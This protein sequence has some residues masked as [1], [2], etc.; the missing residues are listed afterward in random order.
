MVD[1]RSSL[2]LRRQDKRNAP[3]RDD[4]MSIVQPGQNRFSTNGRNR[5]NHH[6]PDFMTDPNDTNLPGPR[7]AV[8]NDSSS[9]TMST[10][11]WERNG[12]H[13]SK[14]H[15]LPFHRN[16]TEKE[17]VDL[18]Q[19]EEDAIIRSSS[20]MA[21]R[22]LNARMHVRNKVYSPELEQHVMN[23]FD[24]SDDPDGEY[25]M[26]DSQG[27]TVNTSSFSIRKEETLIDLCVEHEGDGNNTEV[28]I[29]FKDALVDDLS[30]NEG[31]KIMRTDKKKNFESFDSLSNTFKSMVGNHI[32]SSQAQSDPL[33][34]PRPNMQSVLSPAATPDRAK[35]AISTLFGKAVSVPENNSF[36]E[37]QLLP[38]E[39]LLD[40][41]SHK[42][43]DDDNST[44]QYPQSRDLPTQAPISHTHGQNSLYNHQHDKHRVAAT[45]ENPSL[46][47]IK[48]QNRIHQNDKQ[49]ILIDDPFSYTARST[50]NHRRDAQLNNSSMAQSWFGPSLNY[51]SQTIP[52]STERENPNGFI[53]EHQL[54]D[55]LHEK[56][57]VPNQPF[58]LFKR[59]V[60]TARD[61]KGLL[62][63]LNTALC[64]SYC[65]TT[66]ASCVPITLIPT[67]AMDILSQD[68]DENGNDDAN[69]LEASATFF[70]S[71]VATYA[72][73]G[74][75]FGKFIN[76]PLGDIFG[77]RRVACLYA[78]L[79]SVSLTMLS[80]GQSSWSVIYF[81][82][83]VEFFQSVQ[84]PCIAVIL[85]A[86]YGKDN[87]TRNRINEG[88]H[89]DPQ[90]AS[91]EMVE[92]YEK[93][94]YIT[95]VGSRFGALFAS[96]STSML[97]SLIKD[98]WRAVARL[99]ALGSF[100][101]CIILYLF[102]TDSPG[103]IHDP[104]NPVKEFPAEFSSNQ[105][106]RQQR[107]GKNVTTMSDLI[108]KVFLLLRKSLLVFR[109]NVVPSLRSVLSNYTFW[110]VAIAHSGGLMVCSSVRILG[111]YFR[112][113]SY[114]AISENEAGVVT[115]G[116]SVGVLTGLAIGGNAF[117]NLSANA[118]A[119]KKMITNLY[120]LA[121]TMCYTLSFLALPFIRK[122]IRSS[123]LVA[124]LQVTASFCMGAGVAVQV[125]C[126]P[127]IV[128]QSFGA[129]KGLYLSYTDG[130]ACIVSSMVWRIVGN[131]VEEGNPQG[132]GWFYGW[133]AVALLVILAGLLMVQFVEHYFCRENS[134]G[135]SMNGNR[136]AKDE[137]TITSHDSNRS[138]EHLTENGMRLWRNRPEFLKSPSVM[139]LG[140]PE[141][142]SILSIGDGDDDDDTTTII[143]EDVT[144]PI[145]FDDIENEDLFKNPDDVKQVLLDLLEL[146]G[147]N[148]CVDCQAPYPRWISIIL[149]N[150]IALN[151]R[152]A[153]KPLL[154]P[155][156]CICC[157]ECA[158]SHRKLGTHLVFVRSIDHD[159]FKMHE[160]ASL[161]R[162][163]NIR[164]NMIYEALLKDLSAKP[165]PASIPSQRNRFISTKY[166]KKLWYRAPIP[167]ENVENSID[168]ETSRSAIE[169][170]SNSSIIIRAISKRSV[171]E[172]PAPFDQQMQD[173]YV[174]FVRCGSDDG[175]S[176]L[177][178]KG[179]HNNLDECASNSSDESWHI[180]QNQRR[181]LDDL[182][183]L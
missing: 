71:T 123:T 60:N 116:L 147:N 94:I 176:V 171:F 165:S 154:L 149:P 150:K 45:H 40:K 118:R 91:V 21:V 174:S 2:L 144:L 44:F 155:I 54:L 137:A 57:Y 67:I 46:L 62:N 83:A 85:A 136:S 22:K 108:D 139:S 99:A 124:L 142:N 107:L 138:I 15:L 49:N 75:A 129:N 13:H 11:A 86:H 17:D 63:K 159:T 158:G 112:D 3:K 36:N 110:I 56:N 121:I 170:V 64:I 76:G 37:I 73:L 161:R 50:M 100:L 34:P 93:A 163:G 70:A 61:L 66:A 19:V 178:P 74:T 32:G 179:N 120:V 106:F 168:N 68:D 26:N 109:R 43:N 169:L 65:L 126:I 167:Q 152:G 51:T 164:V 77:A 175:E 8:I 48:K 80:W 181:G 52:A 53:Q 42:V 87:S 5:Q 9:S 72:I 140:S 24:D 20:S 122:G 146:K 84:W 69:S 96:I 35:R 157:S 95:S 7:N 153:S 47:P 173:D 39:S 89:L 1:E 90:T 55:R 115:L 88:S 98:S 79:L 105:Y 10:Y 101:G 92:K 25:E 125:Y 117:A 156:G 132:T 127:A 28:D 30:K 113:T 103:K 128:Q 131:A 6:Q 41:V 172:T 12:L 78:L 130:V 135:Q 177:G 143:F 119:R 182:I 58:P 151:H 162:G 104:Q 111:T 180:S 18:I 133:A 160:V 148:A 114:G 183:N 97:L 14:P 31:G 27:R 33:S 102:V 145:N 82:A 4:A 166:E 141:V 59:V 134:M 29:T 23:S 16:R 38:S 81:C